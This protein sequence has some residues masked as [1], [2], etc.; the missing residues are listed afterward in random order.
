[1]SVAL[2]S[3]FMPPGS[4]PEA[5][6][7]QMYGAPYY[8]ARYRPEAEILFCI[9]MYTPFLAQTFAYSSP[10]RARARN[11]PY[12]TLLVHAICGFSLVVRYHARYVAL[13]VW[14]EPDNVDLAVFSVFALTSFYLQVW[15][16]KGQGPAYR[17]GFQ[18]S[19][20]M[21]PAVFAASWL[22]GQDPALFRVAIKFIDWFSWFR[23]TVDLLPV[24]DSRLKLMKNFGTRL[25][26]TC[27]L[28]GSV[29]V[30]Q[31]GYPSGILLLFGLISAT[32]IM[33]RAIAGVLSG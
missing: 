15:R 7:L 27:I 16:S 9:A 32:M 3:T 14:P 29:A 17:A 18:A 24:I 11:Y 21:H 10:K 1:M 31:S 33:E 25:E 28:S 23:F 22:M 6:N 4:S 20:L 26:L 2:N 8:L 12:L 19:I 13:R 30:Y 5:D